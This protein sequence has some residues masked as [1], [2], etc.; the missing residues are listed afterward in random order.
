MCEAPGISALQLVRDLVHRSVDG[1][2]MVI[3]T[4]IGI[5]V[6][7]SDGTD[8]E[9]LV[10]RADLAMY[11][12][13][14]LGKNTYQLY[15]RSMGSP[16]SEGLAVESDFR[17][18]LDKGEPVVQAQVD[19]HTCPMTGVESLLHWQHPERGLLLPDKFL[20]LA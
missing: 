18:A 13:K 1:Q 17:K 9:I 5:S 14:A 6:C 4:S 2:E 20:P 15:N 12:A 10:K 19:F 7:P 8:L 11:R 3:T 16:C